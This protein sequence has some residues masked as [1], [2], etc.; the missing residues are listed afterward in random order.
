[1]Q[2]YLGPFDGRGRTF[3]TDYFRKISIAIMVV[4][5]GPEQTVSF[6]L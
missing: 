2:Q 6:F 5:T 1:M 3:K 4:T